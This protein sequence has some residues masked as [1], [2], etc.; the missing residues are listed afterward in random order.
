MK[1]AFS[2]YFFLILKKTQK[3]PFSFLRL[4]AVNMSRGVIARSY[5]GFQPHSSPAQVS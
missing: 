3:V 5:F 2:K 4:R 1:K